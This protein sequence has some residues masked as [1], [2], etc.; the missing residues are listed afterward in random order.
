MSPFTLAVCRADGCSGH[1]C[2]H[3]PDP[4]DEAGPSPMVR[5]FSEA[6]RRSEHGVLVVTG[7]L[8]GTLCRSCGP[9][10]TGSAGRVVLVQPCDRS[11]EPSGPAVLVGP[12]RDPA[13]ADAVCHWLRSGS[14]TAQRLPDRLRGYER[15]LRR[16]SPN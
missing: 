2:G 12:I 14:L 15:T 5:T 8:L 1:P 7:C 4:P 10:A 11:R 3:R 13:D 9:S 16:G 6:T